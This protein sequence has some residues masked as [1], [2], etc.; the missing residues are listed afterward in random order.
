MVKFVYRGKDRTADDISK[1]AKEST[2]DYDGVFKPGLSV[3]KPK[4]GENC[5]RILPSA[6]PEHPDWDLVIHTHY[7]VGPG[8]ARYLCLSK[9]K[10]EDCPICDALSSFDEDEQD[11][12]RVQKGSVCWVIDRDNEKAGP[13]L[14]SIP[15]TK[16]RNEIY[17]RSVDKKSRT[18]ILIDDPE[19]GFD[20]SFFRK[21][22]D[23]R[24]QYSGVE[25]S[26]EPSSLHDNP[27]TQDR[28]LS[29]VTEHP[30][31]DC[32]NFF[33]AEYIKKVLFGKAAKKKDE[34]DEDEAPSTRR[35]LKREEDEDEEAEA[36]RS[37]RSRASQ[38]EDEGEAPRSRRSQKED[39]EDD[40]PF[41]EGRS[42]RRAILD[43]D[44]EEEDEPAPKKARKPVEEDDEDD[45][46]EAPSDTAKRALGRLRTAG[47]RGVR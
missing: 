5:V 35:R 42:R 3:Y 2:R 28:W 20:V 18:P 34:D 41:D 12:L 1:K 21:G 14:W 17:E 32:L 6:D 16:V 9:M 43:E 15:F 31:M 30:L 33:E 7:N 4:E 46:D 8:N 23:Q 11:Q 13:Q 44:D 39:P 40:V 37:R 47:Q 25:V 10:E 29:Y 45:E 26:R 27:K 24:T 36:P 38:D 22:T 19:E